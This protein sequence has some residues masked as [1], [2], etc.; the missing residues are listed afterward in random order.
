MNQ[1]PI[2]YFIA[3]HGDYMSSGFVHVVLV[4]IMSSKSMALWHYTLWDSPTNVT[5]WSYVQ[6]YTFVLMRVII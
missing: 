1:K 4:Y 5:V 2:M 3:V 6:R